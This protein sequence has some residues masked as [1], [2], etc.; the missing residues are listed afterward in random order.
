MEVNFDGEEQLNFNLA[1]E[2][3]S[4][5]H[6]EDSKNLQTEDILEK[7]KARP[8][9][10]PPRPTRKPREDGKNEHYSQSTKRRSTHSNDLGQTVV[11]EKIINTTITTTAGGQRSQ[12]ESKNWLTNECSNLSTRFE[13]QTGMQTR[14]S[15]RVEC[16]VVEDQGT[17]SHQ[18]LWSSN[19]SQP[20]EAKTVFKEH[21]V[22]EE[23]TKQG[24]SSS[25][26]FP[27]SPQSTTQTQ[28]FPSSPQSTTQPFPST[29]RQS[30]ETKIDC[31]GSEC[32]TVSVERSSQNM[33]SAPQ[34]QPCGTEPRSGEKDTHLDRDETTQ[35][36][37]PDQSVLRVTQVEQTPPNRPHRNTQNLENTNPPGS[38]NSIS[39]SK[40]E[41]SE[42]SVAKLNVG[43]IESSR[44]L[45]S[46]VDSSRLQVS[47][48]QSEA[49][50]LLLNAVAFGGSQSSPCS[51]SG[52]PSLMVEQRDV[53]PSSDD[54]A[55]EPAKQR[56]RISSMITEVGSDEEPN[57]KVAKVVRPN[58][59]KQSLKRLSE[60]SASC[61]YS[62][63]DS[64]RPTL[65]DLMCQ[66]LQICHSSVGQAI[67]SLLEQI[68]PED[69]EKRNEVQAAIWVMT[70]IVAG[71]LM[72]GLQSN[73]KI[74]HHHHW[75]FH[76]PP[77]H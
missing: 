29:L 52:E 32:I 12:T 23:N 43:E 24:T 68:I 31:G 14:I 20:E 53:T 3:D 74:V 46:T 72:L 76:F 56:P 41:I 50:T 51:I 39:A 15:E 40:L 16:A 27:L 25:Q 33:L 6:G 42:L 48:I 22:R 66:I 59:R 45:T 36:D 44:L 10:P 4:N 58:R 71:C 61:S 9:P 1:T 55:S 64:D 13:H 62:S 70:I 75:D 8:L 5:D 60:A 37:F 38:F 18:Y 73:E 67:H 54:A 21:I 34:S 69:R 57:S 77:P 7:M 26:Q 30:E 17:T 35:T 11:E 47:S 19:S 63:A 28:P 2:E 49:G 65:T